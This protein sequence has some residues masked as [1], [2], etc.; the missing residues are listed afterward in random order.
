METIT[1]CR[2][3]SSKNIEPFFDLGKQPLANSL[4]D[5]ADAN[6]EFFPLSLSYCHECSLVQLNETISP[7]KLFSHYL[8]L[9]GTSLAAHKHARTFF[10]AVVARTPQA[11][12]KGY[13]LE[14]ASNDGTFLVPFK[15]ER[16]QIVGVD[17]AENIAQMAREQGIPTEVVFFGS[18]AASDLVAKH[19]FAEIVFAR[20]VLPHVAGTRDFVDGLREAISDTGT[21]AIEAHY[22]KIIQ[23]D[24]HYDSIYH[25]HLC[26]FT[27]KSM[28]RLLNDHGLYVF[29]V[30]ESPISGGSLVYYAKKSVTDP[31]ASL[32]AYREAETKDKA[33][34]FEMWKDFASRSF[35]HRD[36]I[37]AILR[38]EKAQG[39]KIAG[40][41]ASARSS[42]MLNFCGITTDIVPEIVDMNPLKQGRFT[43]G[44]HIPIRNADDI[45]ATKPDCIF[46]LAWNFKD[47]ITNHLTSHYGFKGDC[48]LPFPKEPHVVVLG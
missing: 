21:V 36:K 45:M 8:W 44:T 28:E 13:V 22:G 33:N 19:G 48:V 46:L 40:W 31:S 20:N 12:K 30:T 38:D 29:D 2:V 18:Q 7:E 41:G 5:K 23:E 35:A 10:D 14:I 43:A 1:T 4:P 37:L 11:G 32:I 47:E 42:T 6:E 17:P 9:T 27:V 24:L 39:R 16:F 15:K 3:C 26:Y 34:D 25:E